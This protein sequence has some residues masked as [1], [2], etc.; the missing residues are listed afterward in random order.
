MLRANYNI[1]RSFVR[2]TPECPGTLKL[3]TLLA[4][5]T[6]PTG[7]EDKVPP[8]STGQPSL[9]L[10]AATVL[11][12]APWFG[13]TSLLINFETSNKCRDREGHFFVYSFGI[14]RKFG[15]NSFVD[16]YSLIEFDWIF[17]GDK[18]LAG[19]PVPNTS[20][21]ILWVG[22]DI[23][24]EQKARSLKFG[25]QAPLAQSNISRDFRVFASFEYRF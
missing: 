18:R 25:A 1:Y 3:V 4:G 24:L 13:L 10:G 5:I 22:P 17:E 21:S 20:N 23:L 6:I 16:V 14:G 2:G 9:L 8:I 15:A 7:G 11:A 19:E 12:R